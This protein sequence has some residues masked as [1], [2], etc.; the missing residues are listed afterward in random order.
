[1]ETNTYEGQPEAQRATMG[2][3]LGVRSA[4]SSMFRL[5]VGMVTVPE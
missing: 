4:C 2:D 3:R 5:K 1:M